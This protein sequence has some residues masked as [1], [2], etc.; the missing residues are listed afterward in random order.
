[1][2]SNRLISRSLSLLLVFVAGIA[3]CDSGPT[4]ADP[5]VVAE[6]RDRY[7]LE[8]E[9]ALPVS[10][11]G[12]LERQTA[13]ESESPDEEEPIELGQTSNP[14]SADDSSVVLVG[15]VGGMPNPFGSETEPNFPWKEGEATFYLVDTTT[16]D[17]F[18][19][20]A[21]EAGVEHAADCPF[22]AREA[23]GHQSS[24]VSV[25][26]LNEQGEPYNIDSRELFD[27]KKGDVVVVRGEA[28]RVGDAVMLFA[29]GL[30]R[31]DP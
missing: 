5:A 7:V 4:Q 30:Y 29:D 31:R 11:L 9:P 18:A 14:E 15:K 6:L 27:L 24:V 16:A 1:M 25:S 28:K 21:S 20:H 10:P 8:V 12:Y 2:T 22:C 3:G 23:R 19:A 17:Y 13:S 26:F